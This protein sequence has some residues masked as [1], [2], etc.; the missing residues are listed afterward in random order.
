MS[1]DLLPVLLQNLLMACWHPEA[2]QLAAREISLL[3]SLHLDSTRIIM[4]F[5]KEPLLLL[6]VP[7]R[8]VLL[9]RKM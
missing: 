6:G 2:V 3:T 4:C 9:A 8:I 5:L 7:W 1:K